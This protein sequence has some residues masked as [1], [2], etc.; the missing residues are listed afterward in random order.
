MGADLILT[1]TRAQFEQVRGMIEAE[2]KVTRPRRHDLYDVFNAVL[3]RQA[4]G[5][6]WRDL[7]PGSPPWRSVHQYFTNW[8]SPPDSGGAPVLTLALAA[9][10]IN[11]ET[12]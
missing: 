11:T 8:N 4:T 5:C 6:S 7:P 12:S 10:D 9:L 3:H 1:I 2:R